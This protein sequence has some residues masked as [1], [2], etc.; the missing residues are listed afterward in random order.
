MEGRPGKGG[1]YPIEL[2]EKARQLYIVHRKFTEVHPKLLEEFGIDLD[3]HT[4]NMWKRKEGWAEE[5][6]MVREAAAKSA[7][8]EAVMELKE[9]MHI[10]I[11]LLAKG[12]R[13]I[14]KKVD[15]EEKELTLNDL[16][17]LIGIAQRY[18]HMNALEDGNPTAIKKTE[19]T[20][21]EIKHLLVEAFSSDPMQAHGKHLPDVEVESDG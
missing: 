12:L 15:D 20:Q 19:L 7:R 8:Q 4:F 3:I 16:T 14:Q 6:R 10:S 1:E 21:T 9:G 17:K 2:K 5:R 18:H 13:A 11:R